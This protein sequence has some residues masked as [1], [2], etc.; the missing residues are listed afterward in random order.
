[1]VLSRRIGKIQAKL[2]MVIDLDRFGGLD[3]LE[4]QGRSGQ[5]EYRARA[6]VAFCECGAQR[7]SD[8]VPVEPDG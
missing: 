2:L 1:L 7:Q 3:D 8:Q 5:A 6:A 4:G